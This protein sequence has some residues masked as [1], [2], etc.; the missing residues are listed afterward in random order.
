[1]AVKIEINIEHRDKL[2]ELFQATKVENYIHDT[3]EEFALFTKILKLKAIRENYK[4]EDYIKVLEYFKEN[5]LSLR[6]KK[7]EESIGKSSLY[8]FLSHAFQHPDLAIDPNNTINLSTKKK[9]VSSINPQTNEDIENTFKDLKAQFLQDIE[10]CAKTQTPIDTYSDLDVNNNKIGCEKCISGY[11]Q[12]K[13]GKWTF[14]ECYLKEQLITKLRNSGI[15]N[16]YIKI[17]YID[18]NL[19]EFAAKKSFAS[20]KSQFKGESINSFISKYV[21]NIDDLLSNGWNLIIEGPTGSCKTTTACIIA[22]NSIKK[23]YSTL[24]IEMQQ[25]RKIWVSDKLSENLEKAKEKLLDVD[26]LIIDDFG[27]EFMSANSDY[28]LSELDNLLRE[29]ISLQKSIIFTTNATPINIQKRYGD[30]IYSLLNT[31]MIHLYIKTKE[32]IR[33]TENLPDFL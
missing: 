6:L 4:I 3:Q 18:E 24:F 17:D 25:L 5:G 2:V 10:N 12:T 28:Q 20:D 21:N 29:R 8:A 16:E 22:K 30:R 32:D 7:G 14:C 11:V 26:L 19:I 27:Q 33:K 23:G 31:K 1:M 9:N 13:D 15:K